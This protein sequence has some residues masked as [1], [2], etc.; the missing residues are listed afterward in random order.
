MLSFETER[1]SRLVLIAP[2]GGAPAHKPFTA[3]L[4]HLPLGIGKALG[5][6]ATRRAV[7]KLYHQELGGR[8]GMEDVLKMLMNHIQHNP[9]FVRSI[10]ET[11]RCVGL[12]V[13]LLVVLLIGC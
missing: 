2:P 4:V 1:V 6:L 9:G 3:K 5:M 8:D 12:S 11:L 7:R 13:T 10:V